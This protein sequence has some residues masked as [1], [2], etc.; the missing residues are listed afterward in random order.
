VSLPLDGTSPLDTTP[1]AQRPLDTTP[2]VRRELSE[3]VAHYSEA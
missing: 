2:P 1:P 3:A